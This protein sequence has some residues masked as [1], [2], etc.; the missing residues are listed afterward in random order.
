MFD[1]AEVDGE[2]RLLVRCDD[3]PEAVADLSNPECLKAILR[4]LRDGAPIRGVVLVHDRERAYGPGATAALETLLR[5]GRLLDHLARRAPSPRF[6]GFTA[7]EVAAACARCPFRP[8]AMF[9]RLRDRILGDPAGFLEGLEEIARRLARY[10]EGGCTTCAG[11]TIQ[12][13]RIVVA[14]LESSGA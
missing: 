14:E 4:H 7:K 11:A 12:D 8:A 13:L 2:G 1:D 6:P 10:T 5:I 3:A 9:E